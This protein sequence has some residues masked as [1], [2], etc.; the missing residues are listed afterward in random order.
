MGMIKRVA[1]A[2]DWIFG[3]TSLRRRASFEIP[4][5]PAIVFR[6]S[7][8]FLELLLFLYKGNTLLIEKQ[9]L[10]HPAPDMK[11]MN[12]FCHVPP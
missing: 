7:L 11:P 3:S 10:E 5:I 8:H 9:I 1:S 12:F 6:F 4:E 2:S